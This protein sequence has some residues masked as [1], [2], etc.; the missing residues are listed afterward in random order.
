[1][2]KIE[3]HII[4]LS[5]SQAQSNSYA[6]ILGESNGKRRLPIV[7]GHYEAQAIALELEKMKPSR[8]LTHDLFFNFA[9]I[10]GINLVEVQITKFHEG[11]FYATLLC[12]NGV[13]LHEIDSRTSD[14][15]ALSIRF[16]CPIFTTEEIMSQAGILFD[17]DEPSTENM[18]DSGGDDLI[19]YFRN[20]SITE[21]ETELQQAVDEEDYE[22]ASLI[23]DEITKRK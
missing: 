19:S 4:G 3:L 6:L 1:M 22:K 12:D 10:F 2:K 11:I 20:L 23:R 7:I 17:D 21:L 5:Y 15:V 16:H 14:A 18:D 9:K 13:S 8:P